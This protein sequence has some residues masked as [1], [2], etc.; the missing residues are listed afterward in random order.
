MN[1]GIVDYDT[2]FELLGACLIIISPFLLGI[3]MCKK[4]NF[5]HGLITYFFF[6]FLLCFIFN[7]LINTINFFTKSQ[8]LLVVNATSSIYNLFYESILL[9]PNIEESIASNEKFILLTIVVFMYLLL[10]MTFMAID[11]IK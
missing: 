6:N 10:H 7:E 2:F 1:I 8:S 11:R 9:I 4:Y 5:F 3:I